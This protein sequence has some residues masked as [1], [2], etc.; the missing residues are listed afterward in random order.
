MIYYRYVIEFFPDTQYINFFYIGKNEFI[1]F[2]QHVFYMAH[3][4][5]LVLKEQ[6]RVIQPTFF[7]KY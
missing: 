6:N 2:L 7:F 3:I 4:T 1:Q 5:Q